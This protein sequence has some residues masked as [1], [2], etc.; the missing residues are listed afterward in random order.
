MIRFEADNVPVECLPKPAGYRLLIAPVKI[1]NKSRGGIEL[2]GESIR[3]M[4][5][6]RNVAKILAVGESCYQ[7]PKFQ[8]GIA[9]DQSKPE[10]W[11]K[12]GD[13]IHYNSY[14]GAEIKINYNG[15]I[16]TLRLIND[17]EV[18][19]VNNDLSVLNFL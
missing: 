17:D 9:L 10:P 7:H 18:Y 19:T 14:T 15:D 8:G 4:E 1:E 3:T 2:P 13:V 11:C 12:V 16:S 6:F 5:Y